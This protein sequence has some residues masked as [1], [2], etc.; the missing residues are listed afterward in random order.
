M[1]ILLKAQNI[2]DNFAKYKINDYS[3]LRNFDF[4]PNND[5]S[6]S[7]LSPFVTHRILLEYELINDIKTKYKDKNSTKFIQKKKHWSKVHRRT[8][9]RSGVIDGDADADGARVVAGEQAEAARRA[10]HRED[11]VRELEALRRRRREGLA[12]RDPKG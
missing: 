7:K 1:S 9:Q 10:R 11:E 5:G 12:L 3:K 8:T 6:V 2:W 4:G